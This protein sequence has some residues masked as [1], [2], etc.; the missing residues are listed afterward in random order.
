[1]KQALYKVGEE[2]IL[3]SVS[4]PELSGECIVLEVKPNPTGQYYDVD[5][6]STGSY[7]SYKLTIERPDPQVPWWTEVVIKKKHKPSDQ[8]FDRLMSSLKEPQKA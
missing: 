4:F 7:F 8:S 2:V 5:G 3:Q 6:I 1:M